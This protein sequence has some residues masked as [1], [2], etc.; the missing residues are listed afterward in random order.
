MPTLTDDDVTL[1]LNRLL[2]V[3]PTKQ[4]LKA[5][6]QRLNNKYDKS[7]KASD[8]VAGELLKLREE[9]VLTKG[10]KDQLE[11]HAERLQTI[12]LKLNLTS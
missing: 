7:V 2:L 5:M 6:E 10:H 8:K 9:I 3:L 11:D 1:I 12:E 4:E